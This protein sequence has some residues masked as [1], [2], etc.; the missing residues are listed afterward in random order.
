[1]HHQIDHCNE[2]HRFTTARQDFVVFGQ[3][4]VLVEPTECALDDPS[5]GQHC[6]FPNGLLLNYFNKATIPARCPVDKLAGIAA[7][8]PDDLQSPPLPAEFLDE[9]FASLAVLLVGRMNHQG[10]DQAERIHDDMALAAGDL[11]P[12]VV[13]TIPPFP[14]VLTDWL[15]MMAALG[16]GL[17]PNFLRR[18]SRSRS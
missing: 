3:S 10:D 4:A 7:I 6:E 17:R 16:V 5:F 18:R 2:D 13:A 12:R 1:M 14:A 11:L 15:S 8:R 9:Q